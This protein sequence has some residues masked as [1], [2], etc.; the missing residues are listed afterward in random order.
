MNQTLRSLFLLLFLSCQNQSKI[1]DLNGVWCHQ[2]DQINHCIYFDQGKCI[3]DKGEL[4]DFEILSN[5]KIQVKYKTDTLNYQIE[6]N[7]DTLSLRNSTKRLFRK[8]TK[9]PEKNSQPIQGLY[10][11]QVSDFSDFELYLGSDRKILLRINYHAKFSAGNYATTLPKPLFDIILELTKRI[12]LNVPPNL[13][14]TIISDWQE[15]GLKLVADEDYFIYHNYEQV[16]KNHKNLVSMLEKIPYFIELT[17]GTV[18]ETLSEIKTFQ[19]KEFERN[20]KEIN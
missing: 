4:N 18:G 9:S 12:E 3:L 2:I 16:D 5:H 10:F 19:K 14:K 15:W 1:V 7:N 20:L 17:S 6:I 13:K 11:S 8:F